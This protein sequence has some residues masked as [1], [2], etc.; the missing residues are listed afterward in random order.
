MKLFILMFSIFISF[1]V[2]AHPAGVKNE[3]GTFKL[4]EKSLG[5]MG[6]TFSRLDVEGPWTISKEALV[7]IKFTQGVYRRYEGDITYVIVR[8]LKETSDTI[9]IQSEDLE[10]GD[11]VAVK[12][13]HFL[14]L[15]EAD[16]NSD[17]VD[18]C[19]N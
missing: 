1:Q 14:R 12:G 8:V 3:D 6:I 9:T 18:S 19:S 13:A 16:L 4:S 15:A 5:V 7:K 17:T 11:E 10:V 2:L